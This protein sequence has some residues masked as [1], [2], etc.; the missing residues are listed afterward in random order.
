MEVEALSA[1]P[2]SKQSTKILIAAFLL[3]PRRHG[4]PQKLPSKTPYEEGAVHK[5]GK[6]SAH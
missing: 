1:R 5:D 2:L 4:T 6:P 3:S